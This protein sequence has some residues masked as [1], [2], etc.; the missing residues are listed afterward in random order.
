MGPRLSSW[1]LSPEDRY[2]K[3]KSREEL[4]PAWAKKICRPDISHSWDQGDLPNYMCREK[5]LGHQGRERVPGNIC[6][7]SLPE[8]LTLKSI[9]VNKRCM[10]TLGRVLSHIAIHNEQDDWLEKT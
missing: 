3:I 6:P 1:T 10:C 9:L 8:T 4:S 7:A 5:F 2:F